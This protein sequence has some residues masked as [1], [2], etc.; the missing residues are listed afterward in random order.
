MYGFSLCWLPPLQGPPLAVAL[1]GLD[2]YR[3]IIIAALLMDQV[4]VC[5][6]NKS[7]SRASAGS[8]GF[9]LSALNWHRTRIVTWEQIQA[10]LSLARVQG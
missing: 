1:D 8:S 5:G 3:L 6:A 4:L 2:M 10:C 9:D 7:I